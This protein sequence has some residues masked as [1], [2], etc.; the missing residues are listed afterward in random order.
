MPAI[1]VLRL[2]HSMAFFPDRAY[3]RPRYLYTLGELG[4]RFIDA[5][6][7]MATAFF[8]RYARVYRRAGMLAT[9]PMH[10]QV[11]ERACKPEPR[12]IS[13]RS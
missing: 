12:L 10:F 11:D 6:L 13:T 8:Q 3:Q 5:F 9:V 2:S 4:P 1:D 7:R